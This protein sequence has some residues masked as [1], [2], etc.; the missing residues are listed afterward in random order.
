MDDEDS[1]TL[2]DLFKSAHRPVV[3]DKEENATLTDVLGLSSRRRSS[4]AKEWL[5]SSSSV[6]KVRLSRAGNG[7]WKGDGSRRSS[8]CP[9]FRKGD[10]VWAKI[11]PYTWWPG[12]VERFRRSRP[13][14]S[15]F[16]RRKNFLA[17]SSEVCGFEEFYSERLRQVRWK[18]SD[19]IGL[20][21]EELARSIVLGLKCSCAADAVDGD[22]SLALKSGF[23]SSEIFCFVLDKAVFPRVSSGEI[24]TSVRISAELNAFCC[25]RSICETSEVDERFFPGG[26]LGF[27]HDMA[28]NSCLGYKEDCLDR[29]AAQLNAFRRFS[30]VKPEWFYQLDSD[31][32]EDSF[33]CY[34]FEV[35][36]GRRGCLY[37][38][39]IAITMTG[40]LEEDVQVELQEESEALEVNFKQ[41]GCEICVINRMDL[42]LFDM[43]G[44]DEC[45]FYNQPQVDGSESAVSDVCRNI[46][47]VIQ[48]SVTNCSPK[49]IEVDAELLLDEMLA[50]V[51]D[52]NDTT[53]TEVCS[54]VDRELVPS[55]HMLNNCK[56]VGSNGSETKEEGNTDMQ[57]NR[58]HD[59]SAEVPL[60]SAEKPLPLAL[61]GSGR[62]LRSFPVTKSSRYCPMEAHELS[63]DQPIADTVCK[64]VT[65]KRRLN[66]CIAC[67]NDTL[68]RSTACCS[69]EILGHSG[70]LIGEIYSK[71]DSHVIQKTLLQDKVGSNSVKLPF[72]KTHNKVSERKRMNGY[73]GSISEYKPPRK[74]QFNDHLA[75]KWQAFYASPLMKD[76]S[77][78]NNTTP[79]SSSVHKDL[80]GAS[81][82]LNMKFPMH[83]ALPSK[84]DLEMKFRVFGLLDRSRTRIFFYTGAA[85]V[86][87]L[88][89]S[90]SV[91]AYN[92]ATRK[93]IF[94]QANVRFWFDRYE[95]HRKVELKAYPNDPGRTYSSPD[96]KSCLRKSPSC[97][98]SD[99][100]NLRVRFSMDLHA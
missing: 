84:E 73:S 4:L 68:N 77:H 99:K 95:N 88:R 23:D 10:I 9:R 12:R 11:F 63:V 90:D 55:D 67:R 37:P 69:G 44:K 50:V 57:V 38:N 21:L 66:E 62:C 6:Q 2:A 35:D 27:V 82:S 46:S 14:V 98:L 26:V 18:L 40:D 15:L 72:S 7:F 32:H 24:A 85:K 34:N 17:D 71:V 39:E 74:K 83:F 56:D 31:L 29:A 91:A 45:L 47:H 87:F 41:E 25:S 5:R 20:A 64:E 75:S 48:H 79:E 1:A 52:T 22:G 93:N 59:S 28:I 33:P 76:E 89:Q 13:L 43:D 60:S 96:L 100:K 97:Q 42:S 54:T 86:V 8:P 53:P 61:P 49:K 58:E 36:E 16:F 51:N 92:Y 30:S 70:P 94:G 81:T 80:T 78:L 65:E 19:E 3:T